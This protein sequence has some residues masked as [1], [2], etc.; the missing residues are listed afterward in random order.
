MTGGGA[1]RWG[2][3]P[4]AGAPDLFPRPGSAAYFSPVSDELGDERT[5]RCCSD[6]VDSCTQYLICQLRPRTLIV[7][8]GA[9]LPR[10]L[11]HRL[12]LI[13]WT[14]LSADQKYGKKTFG[15]EGSSPWPSHTRAKK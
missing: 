11:G 9:N 2:P 4:I 8:L 6:D 1:G 14:T 15:F 5:R 10:K 13:T 12:K 7:T 3:P